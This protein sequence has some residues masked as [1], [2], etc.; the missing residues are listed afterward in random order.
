MKRCDY[1]L[2]KDAHEKSLVFLDYLVIKKV[3]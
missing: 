2:N 1:L 3:V